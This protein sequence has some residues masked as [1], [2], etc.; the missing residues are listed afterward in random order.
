MAWMFC[1]HHKQIN[2]VFI[3]II[4]SVVEAQYDASDYIINV[5]FVCPKEADGTMQIT[6]ETDIPDTLPFAYCRDPFTYYYME[7][8]A[9][10]NYVI[11]VSFSGA[12]LDGCVFTKAE[13]GEIY[14]LEVYVPLAGGIFTSEDLPHLVMCSF[15]D[16]SQEI[17]DSTI[18][19]DSAQPIEE[20]LH[21]M[22]KVGDSNVDLYLENI[23]QE[24]VTAGVALGSSIRIV[25][26]LKGDI[27]GEESFQAISCKAVSN[28]DEYALLLG[29]CGDGIIVARNKGFKTEGKKVTSPYF[30]SF[31]IRGSKTLSFDCT[32]ALCKSNCDGD[33]CPNASVRRRREVRYVRVLPNG[34]TKWLS[35]DDILVTDNNPEIDND[36]IQSRSNHS[37]SNIQLSTSQ[38]R[39]SEKTERLPE[40]FLKL[41]QSDASIGKAETKIDFND[42]SLVGDWDD[43]F[44][45]NSKPS[46]VPKT[47][48]LHDDISPPQL[49]KR[50]DTSIW[51]ILGISV[52]FSVFLAIIMIAMTRRV[53]AL[54]QSLVTKS[55]PTAD[56]PPSSPL[57]TMDSVSV[58]KNI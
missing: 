12:D 24:R 3:L 23:L 48:T 28:N 45:S 37:S 25:A 42:E 39:L 46:M 54:L 40:S 8:N 53:L 43:M 9:N 29:G 15:E 36:I 17:S 7:I 14:T 47:S 21:T 57:T 6:V 35:K 2:A 34:K 19:S 52:G 22:G 41:A 13:S 18:F 4:C 11:D 20:S 16:T 33:S 1:G 10:D 30:R 50:V 26:E 44:K 49:T 5:D 27:P 31:R 32:F 56:A 38:I 58:V 51:L 55:L